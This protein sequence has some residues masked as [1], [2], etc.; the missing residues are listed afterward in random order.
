VIYRQFAPSP[1]LRGLVDRL[2]WLE[3]PA[4]A[5]G[6]DPIPPDGHT[7][8]I[9]HG[10]DP[11]R[12]R[13]AGGEWS[14]QDRVLLA[15]QA[16]RALQVAPSGLA[17]VVGARLLPHA[18]YAIFGQP[19][20]QITD[21]VVGL[22]DVAPRFARTLEDDVAPREDGYA[23]VRALDAAL[24]RQV[25][26]RSVPAA[27]VR[28]TMQAIEREGL[29]KVADLADSAGIST[30]Q[31]ERLFHEQV[32]LSPKRF[33]RILRFQAALHAMHSGRRTP[34][35]DVALSHGFYDQAHFIRDF[36]AL[37]GTS[38][39]AFGLDAWSLSA[40]FSAVRRAPDLAPDVAFVQDGTP[41]APVA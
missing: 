28:A 35:V 4:G 11:F 40:V 39:A 34:W 3:G 13:A 32:G 24:L 12:R 2:W 21:A 20:H 36:K 1:G 25:S 23:M 14:V 27:A 19:Q 17:R 8:I 22:R 29:L 5:I 38:P 9:V 41:P 7:E 6:A 37:A 33:L 26:H 30:R 10:G 18:A 31:L 16:T 15:G